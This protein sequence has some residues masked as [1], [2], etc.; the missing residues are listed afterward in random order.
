MYISALLVS[1]ICLGFGVTHPSS[2]KRTIEQRQVP[3]TKPGPAPV[4]FVDEPD[5]QDGKY[6]D[7]TGGPP[8]PPLEGMC[9]QDPACTSVQKSNLTD[10]WNDA[11]AIVEAQSTF[12]S[13]Y[14]YNFAHTTW[15]GNDWNATGDR[16]I[17]FRTKNIAANFLRIAR[18][19]GGKLGEKELIVW[20]CSDDADL[21]LLC[22]SEDDDPLETMAMTKYYN[23]RE[24]RGY[25]VQT[26]LFCPDFFLRGKL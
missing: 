7:L 15:I 18:L 23:G 12:V 20:R 13:G 11:K 5:I 19:F 22:G 10:A 24:G 9:S 14:D 21:L 4:I 16:K 1:C 2:H 25:R 6:T 8:F 3:D 17:N 26:T